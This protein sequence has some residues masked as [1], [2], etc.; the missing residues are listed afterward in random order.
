LNA[1][2]I[3]EHERRMRERALPL[4]QTE[5]PLPPRELLGL[6]G[7]SSAANFIERGGR[8]PQL[9][10]GFFQAKLSVPRFGGC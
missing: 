6:W 5:A 4:T 2:T 7:P 10:V 8:N 3:Q 9:A 1:D